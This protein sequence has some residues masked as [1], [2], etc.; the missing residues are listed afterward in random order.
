MRLE[1]NICQLGKE[2]EYE[3]LT[4]QMHYDAADRETN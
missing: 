1:N 2:K 4:R 3:I